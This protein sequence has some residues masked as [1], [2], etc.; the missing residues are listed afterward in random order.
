MGDKEQKKANTPFIIKTAKELNVDIVDFNKGER[1]QLGS[2][3]KMP[4]CSGKERLK[5]KNGVK[6]HSTQK[7][8]DL[9]YRIIAISSNINDIVLDPFGGTMTTAAMA[10]KLGRKYISF[11]QNPMYIEYGKKRV[12]SVSF[13]E[14][15]IARATF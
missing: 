2:V 11:E 6:L 7:P 8:Q 10:K 9:L 15:K 3:W 4:V 14:S 1:R 13:E 5:D 12:E